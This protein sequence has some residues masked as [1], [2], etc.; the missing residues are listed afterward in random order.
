MLLVTQDH[1]MK[2]WDVDYFAAAMFVPEVALLGNSVD[3]IRALGP[4]AERK[5]ASLP[6][7]TDDNVSATV[8]ELLVGAG[9]VSAWLWCPK[10]RRERCPTTKS[11]VLVHFGEQSSASVAWASRHT[12]WMKPNA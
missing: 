7:M 12:N 2:R 10:T 3:E 5:H 1:L 8:Y 11:Q 6:S 9:K 4:E